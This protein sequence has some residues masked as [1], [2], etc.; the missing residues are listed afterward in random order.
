[1][2]HTAVS[3]WTTGVPPHCCRAVAGWTSHQTEWVILS[4]RRDPHRK[5]NHQSTTFTAHYFAS[6]T[7][8]PLLSDWRHSH[9]NNNEECKNYNIKSA[10]FYYWRLVFFLFSFTFSEEEGRGRAAPS[11]RHHVM[12]T[13]FIFWYSVRKCGRRTK[14][15]TQT[16][17]LASFSRLSFFTPP[18]TNR[19]DFIV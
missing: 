11:W 9:N 1:M 7:P 16:D 18:R 6:T 14:T 4:P 10:V 2:A 19:E 15:E 13:S 3:G 5:S 12:L 17:S 8:R